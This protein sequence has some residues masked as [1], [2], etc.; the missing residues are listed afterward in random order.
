MGDSHKK[1]FTIQEENLFQYFLSRKDSQYYHWHPIFTV[2][3]GI[4][5]R[6][7][8]ITGLRWCDIDLEKGVIDVNHTLVYYNHATNGCYFNVHTPKTR[9]GER[10]IPMLEQVKKHLLKKNAIR[11]NTTSTVSVSL[12]D[13]WIL[14]L[15]TALAVYSI[16]GH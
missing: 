7:G 1:A 16:R 8:K 5:M 11:K 14:S 2:M 4:G 9:A 10:K 3:L 12:T 15:S 13:I 6:V